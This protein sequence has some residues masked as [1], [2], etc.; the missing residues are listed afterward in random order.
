MS[1]VVYSDGGSRNNPGEAGIGVVVFNDNEKIFTL[2]E[3]L[4]IAT[5][6]RAEYQGA[7]RAL[8]ELAARGLTDQEVEI[9]MDSKLVVEQ[10][11]G[12]WKIKEPALREQ[13]AKLAAL[14]E[15]FP[16][17]SFTYIPREENTEADQLANDAM[18]RGI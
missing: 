18:D 16:S 2:S 14:I 10:I 12:N 11:Q 6:N 17:V 1:I 4:G 7:I 8:T 15:K 13:A 5:N 3:Y 9:R